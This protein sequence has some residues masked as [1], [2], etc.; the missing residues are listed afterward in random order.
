MSPN[1]L[2]RAGGWSFPLVLL[3]LVSGMAHADI[4]KS[5]DGMSRTTRS[6]ASQALACASRMGRK[7]DLLIV[8]DM[9][10]PSSAKRLWAID[11]R[12]GETVIR[13]EVA[14]GRGS[15][16]GSKG[17]AQVFSNTPGSLMTSVGLYSIAEPYQN[18]KDRGLATR[19]RLDGLMPG[20]ND[21][22]RQRAVV[23]HPAKYVRDGWAGHSEG[24]PAVS[25]AA[26]DQLTDHGLDNAILWIEGDQEGLAE[27][28]ASCSMTKPTHRFRWPWQKKLPAKPQWEPSTIEALNPLFDFQDDNMCSVRNDLVWW[29]QGPIYA[30]AV[31]TRWPLTGWY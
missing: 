16:P 12:T 3:S 13:T 31:G 21:N 6:H 22:A 20:F 14:H 26:L 2:R 1:S 11:T 8:A 24:C 18:D 19:R 4:P 7:P 29:G 5:I 9:R 27:A 15:D 25:Y 23:L 17:R 10:L 30:E 28:V